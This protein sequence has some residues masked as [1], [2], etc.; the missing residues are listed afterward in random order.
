MKD[1]VSSSIELDTKIRAK[2]IKLL[3]TK[4]EEDDV[5]QASCLCRSLASSQLPTG[6][7][8]SSKKY[9]FLQAYLIIFHYFPIEESILCYM[10]LDLQDFIS[11]SGESYWLCALL[12]NR[13]NYLKYLEIQQTI[14]EQ[15][16]FSGVCNVKFLNIALKTISLRFEEKLRHPRRIVRRKGYKDKGSQGP[17]SSRA[18]RAGV[19]EDFF[20]SMYQFLKEEKEQLRSV[21]IQLLQEYLQGTRDL[22]GDLLIEFRILPRGGKENEQTDRY[23]EVQ[24]YI[25][26]RSNE[27]TVEKERKYRQ[28]LELLG[29]EAGEAK[30]PTETVSE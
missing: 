16:F 18:L 2:I 13:D 25:K 10:F 3:S 21:K 8:F 7:K 12:S 29:R 23:T 1:S 20:L 26:R 6:L 30:I 19:N 14:T 24:D 27:K 9:R 5:H 22:N 11:Q 17:P 28:K 15:E 4:T